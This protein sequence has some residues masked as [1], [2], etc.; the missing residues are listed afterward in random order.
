[1]GL[2]GRIAKEY[3]AA[4]QL[5]YEDLVQEGNLGLVIAAQRFDPELGNRLSTYA[6]HWI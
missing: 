4:G 6:P 1:V 5:S 3:H 2:V